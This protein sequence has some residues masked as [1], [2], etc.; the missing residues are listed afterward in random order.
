MPARSQ[1]REYNCRYCQEC[2]N[3]DETLSE[4]IYSSDACRIA[5]NS[6]NGRR[7]RGA[8]AHSRSP[9]DNELEQSDND[10]SHNASHPVGKDEVGTNV[11]CSICLV[12]KSKILSTDCGHLCV[13]IGCSKN[14][15]N[16]NDNCPICRGPWKNLLQAYF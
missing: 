6:R 11:V 10:G 12:N 16:R 9:S 3:D 4:H 13:C 7:R 8:R 1:N 2:F 5:H 15:Y 14:I